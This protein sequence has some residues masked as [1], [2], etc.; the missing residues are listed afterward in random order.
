MSNELLG[1][2]FELNWDTAQSFD[3]PTW[4]KQVSVGDIGFEPGNE[5]VEIPIRIPV[6]VYKKGRADWTLT[7]QSNYNKDNAFL[8]AV[9]QAINFGT[10]IHLAISDG[11]VNTENY[12]HAWWFL[13]GPLGASLDEASQYDV[14]GK[15]HF[16]RGVDDDELPAFVPET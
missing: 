12:W 16:D 7:F 4:T 1:D 11:N 6:K 2:D 15:V 3:S 9:R 14:E 5:Q 8:N 13:S 10:K